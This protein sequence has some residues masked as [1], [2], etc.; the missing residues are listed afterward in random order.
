M[1]HHTNEDSEYAV[2][3]ESEDCCIY[4]C[5]HGCLHL[6]F[7]DLNIRLDDER[8]AELAEAVEQAAAKMPKK[9]VGWEVIRGP[10]H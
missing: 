7:G 5:E 1:S 10:A 8:F 6:Q 3:G 4:R 2:L 9:A